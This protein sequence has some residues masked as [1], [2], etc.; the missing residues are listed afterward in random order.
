M[1]RER[2]REGGRSKVAL[3]YTEWWRE[4][5][6]QRM[7]DALQIYW[8]SFFFLSVREREPVLLFE[9]LYGGEKEDKLRKLQERKNERTQA[10]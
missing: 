9:P 6:S 4:R 5:H 1:E 2:E 10:S 8:L 7:K 3:E